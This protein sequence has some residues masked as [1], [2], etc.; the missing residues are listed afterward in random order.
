MCL[1]SRSGGVGGSGHW[2]RKTETRQKQTE[3]ESEGN[4]G[5]KQ[6]NRDGDA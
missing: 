5:E 3:R 4:G 6:T 2:E 1:T